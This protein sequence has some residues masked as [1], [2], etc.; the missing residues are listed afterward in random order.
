MAQTAV[1]KNTLKNYDWARS[2]RMAL[3]GGG[4]LVDVGE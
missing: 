2:G 4:V 3:Y 1:E